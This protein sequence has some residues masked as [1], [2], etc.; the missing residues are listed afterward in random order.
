MSVIHIDPTTR[1]EFNNAVQAAFDMILAEM[2]NI[3]FSA[4]SYQDIAELFFNNGFLQGCLA[5]TDSDDLRET[6]HMMKM[7]I[8]YQLKEK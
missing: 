3:D 7:E 8:D 2:G 4:M 1:K 5:M 6:L